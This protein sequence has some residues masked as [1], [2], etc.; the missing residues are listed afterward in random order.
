MTETKPHSLYYIRAVVWCI[1]VCVPCSKSQ[2]NLCQQKKGENL[3]SAFYNLFALAFAFVIV[4]FVRYSCWNWSVES[5]HIVQNNRIATALVSRIN[6][7]KRNS[8]LNMW[9]FYMQVHCDDRKH[10]PLD[11]LLKSTT[12]KW[13]WKQE[14]MSNAAQKW[15]WKWRRKLWILFACLVPTMMTTS[16]MES[17]FATWLQADYEFHTKFKVV[18]S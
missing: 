12:R 10:N 3:V 5:V 8:L 17:Q 7:S 11:V 4:V 6:W 14:T 16:S 1:A 13:S 9:A 2:T 15:K 18:L